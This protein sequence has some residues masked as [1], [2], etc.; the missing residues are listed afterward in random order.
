M[1]IKTDP[2]ERR[3][4]FHALAERR[5]A[6]FLESGRSIPWEEVRRYLQDRLAGKR[7]KRPVARKF[8][9]A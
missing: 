1:N 9:G 2:A 6:E 4:E 5:Y 7:V 3:S 8:T